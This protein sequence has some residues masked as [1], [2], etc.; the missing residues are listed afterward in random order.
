MS[1]ALQIIIPLSLLT[2]LAII[3][4]ITIAFFSKKFSVETDPKV[5]IVENL[6]SGANCGACGFAG[7]SAFA[8]ALVKGEATLSSC[9]ATSMNAKEEIAKVLGSEDLGE[10]SIVLVACNGGNSCLDKYDYQGYG[11]CSSVELLAGGRKACPVGC[12][13]M[14]KCIIECPHHAID[15]QNGYSIVNQDKCIQCGVCIGHCP[16]MLIKRV[17]SNALYYIAC[18]ST[19]KGKEVRSYCKNGC[20]GCQICVKNCKEGALTFENN[21]P[22]FDY[23]KCTACG[24]CFEKCPAKCIKKL[25]V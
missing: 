13:G 4:S 3:F 14:S 20:I 16:K 8:E 2:G 7:C 21:L 18:S 1:V 15:L 12:I 5:E 25:D 23:T 6:L 19:D 11:D 10:E 9:N 17:P 22:V 24:V